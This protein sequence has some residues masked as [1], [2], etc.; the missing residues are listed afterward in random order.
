[1]TSKVDFCVF[2]RKAK[3]LYF[4]QRTYNWYF[5]Y[6][7]HIYSVLCHIT[8][9]SHVFFGTKMQLIYFRTE[10]FQ[11]LPMFAG[12]QDW[13]KT[14]KTPKKEWYF[15]ACNFTKSITPPWAFF[16]FLTDIQCF[17]VF[18]FLLTNKILE[19]NE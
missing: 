8:G 15:S 17:W 16:T 6:S 3:P 10:I 9:P 13:V 12:N 14:W 4:K 2:P 19:P 11:N 5:L 1:M 18:I 7:L